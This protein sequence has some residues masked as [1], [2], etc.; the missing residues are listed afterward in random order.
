M[1]TKHTQGDWIA[2]DGQ[3]YP[4]ET[5]KTLALIPY[6]DTEDEEQTANAN[7]MAAAK[8]LLNA[9]ELA[10]AALKAIAKVD[11]LDSTNTG[12]VIADAI[13]KATNP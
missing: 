9:L 5:G 2:H 10:Q 13:Q 1:T 6:Y 11:D 12:R 3:I 7:L 8:D 4:Q